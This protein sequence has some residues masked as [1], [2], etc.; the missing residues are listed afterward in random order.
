MNG[1][2]N[3]PIP[4]CT[5]KPL[6][7]NVV[8][9]VCSYRGTGQTSCTQPP[10]PGFVATMKCPKKYFAGKQSMICDVDGA[11][12][13]VRPWNTCRHQCGVLN[14]KNDDTWDVIIREKDST[15]NL[16]HG[17][18]LNSVYV[19]TQT[20]CVEEFNPHE[21]IIKKSLGRSLVQS[22]ENAGSFTL[23]RT[24]API[25]FGSRIMPICVDN[26]N[27]DFDDGYTWS[28]DPIQACS[29]FINNEDSDYYVGGSCPVNDTECIYAFGTAFYTD[30]KRS[31]EGVPRQY[32]FGVGLHPRREGENKNGF[33][34][35]DLSFYQQFGEREYNELDF[36]EYSPLRTLP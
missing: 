5:C 30:S 16:C 4:D 21:L 31:I 35:C 36:L 23:L 11:W 25:R 10:L 24:K 34:D 32:L 13:S 6:S 3:P 18:I 7:S 27:G 17:S 22:L 14:D 8:S 33:Y 20:S 2:W 26:G 28:S 15:A 1:K 9:T 19:I 29:A 12:K